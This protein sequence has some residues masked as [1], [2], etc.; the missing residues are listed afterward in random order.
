MTIIR[1]FEFSGDNQITA[2]IADNIDDFLWVAFAQNSGGNCII[3]KQAQFQP[4]QTY[5][6][7]E[8]SVD[9]VKA[10][11]VDSSKIYIAYEDSSLIGEFISKSN[12]LSST[13]IEISKTTTES[14]V[15]ILVNGSDVWFLLPGSSS[16]ENAKLLL[17]D[18]S[19]NFDQTVDL[20]SSGEEVTNASKIAISDTNDLWITTNED[21]ASIVRVF[22]IS[23]GL[24]DFEITN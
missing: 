6:S 18:T 8:R 12:P 14:P 17:Y 9:E 20:S 19:G 16:G 13:P 1:R 10:F 3:E 7:L 23:G 24:Y 21:P 5:F 11:A 4:N 22:E 2:Q 15:D